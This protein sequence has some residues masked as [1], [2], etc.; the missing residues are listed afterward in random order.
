LT[1]LNGGFCKAPD[2]LGSKVLVIC[3]TVFCLSVSAFS[4][5]WAHYRGPGYDGIVKDGSVNP[6]NF[7][8]VWKAAVGIGFS[9]I[10]VVDGFAYTMGH[11]ND[12]DQVIAL[13][14][15]NGAIVWKHT[16]AAK[17]DPNLYEG[18]PNATPTYDEG[19]VFTLSR[20]G[21]IFC[22]DAK[23]GK[24]IWS[25]HAKNYSEAPT[26]GYSGAAT[27]LGDMVLFNI[28]THGLALNKTSGKV[29]WKSKKGK[30]GYAPAIPFKRKGKEVL[31]MFTGTGLAVVEAASGTAIWNFPWETS[32]DVNAAA[33]IIFDDKIFI[34]SGYRRGGAVVAFNGDSPEKIW[35]NDNMKAQF[36]SPVLHEGFIYGISGDANRRCK[37]VCLDPAT[38]EVKWEENSKFGSVLL[39]GNQLIVLD[40]RGKLSLVSAKPDG[41]ELLAEKEV[42]SSRSWTVPTLVNG[43]LYLRDAQGT[44]LCLDVK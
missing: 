2:Q 33:P 14:I 23:T 26:W 4:K 44:V 10:I 41:Y 39:A 17:L 42:L 9:S 35:E 31:A 1:F 5:D 3:A 7:K 15:T 32:Y 37:L 34:T 43:L 12:L 13:D 38:G 30:A 25:D 6:D 19:K 36:N 21:H 29:I 16:Y 11:E 27:V 24:V 40:E 20:E 22:L 18:G 28:G 8:E